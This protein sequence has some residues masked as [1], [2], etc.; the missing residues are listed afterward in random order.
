MGD[1]FLGVMDALFPDDDKPQSVRRQR[2]VVGFLML[3]TSPVVTW[4]LLS[5]FYNVAP[6]GKIAWAGEVQAVAEAKAREAV[7]P[8]IEQMSRL[9]SQLE[10]N[11][12]SANALIADSSYFQMMDRVRR[13]CATPVTDGN[14]RDRL[15]REI[16]SFVDRY[17][18]ATNDANFRA[19]TCPEL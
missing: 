7:H 17:R 9:Q 1:W 4:I 19:P 8:L 12:S 14:E 11:T 3:Y 13:R 16:N 10:A 15:Q 2:K 6:F 18:V 5:L